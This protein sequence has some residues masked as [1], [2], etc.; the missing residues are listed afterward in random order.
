MTITVELLPTESLVLIF[1]HLNSRD[2]LSAAKSCKKFNQVIIDFLPIKYPSIR[3]DFQYLNYN[4]VQRFTYKDDRD[5][6]ILLET[7]RLYHNYILINFNKEHT[8]RLGNKWLQLFKKQIN[9]RCIRIK[10]DCMDLKQLSNLIKLTHRLVFV[11]IDGYRTAKMDEP[12]D[13][14]DVASLPSLK[15][16]KIHSFLDT[17]PQIFK[18]FQDCKTLKS[19][20]LSSLFF[21]NKKIKS[22]NDFILNQRALEQLELIGLDS[23]SALFSYES[24]NDVKFK[25]EKI[26]IEYNGYSLN[27][28]KFSTFFCHQKLFKEVKLALDLRNSLHHA[29]DEKLCDEMIRHIMTMDHLLSVNLLVNKCSLKDSEKFQFNNRSITKLVF[30]NESRGNNNLLVSLLHCLPNLTHLELACDYSDDVLNQL[31]QLIKLKNLKITDYFQGLLKSIKCSEYFESIS[32]QY[33]YTKNSGS[34][35]LE[36][37]RNNTNIKRIHIHHSIDFIDDT[38]VDIITSACPNLEDFQMTDSTAKNITENAYRCFQKN[39]KNLKFLKLTN[40]PSQMTL[41]KHQSFHDLLAN[42]KCI[43]S[44]YIICIIGFVVLV[45]LMWQG[46]I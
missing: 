31:P 24:L 39:C 4:K 14:S 20:S 6:N 33:C 25:L 43:I 35:W 45:V 40:K 9:A 28:E 3:I 46:K 5:F 26:N 38:I 21:I 22:I 15:H 8:D 42:V 7:N 29:H 1:N 34:D 16:L 18:I 32:L 30:E 37:L 41:N 19:I 17:S 23:H 27:L 2:L 11:E 10:S 44:F 13:D 36:F 12:L